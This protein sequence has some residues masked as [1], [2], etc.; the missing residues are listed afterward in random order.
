MRYGL[1]VSADE[2]H[3][4]K[5]TRINVFPLL[6]NLEYSPCLAEA[7]EIFQNWRLN[8]VEFHQDIQN[9]VYCNGI[10][11]G[12]RADWDFLAEQYGNAREDTQRLRML[13][14]LGCSNSDEILT[15]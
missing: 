6:C 13:N 9:I 3:T 5:L 15:G 12:S 4:R 7:P 2:E 1:P 11:Q 14:A 8:D 10:R